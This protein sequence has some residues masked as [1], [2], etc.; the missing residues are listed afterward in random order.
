MSSSLTAY[1]AYLAQSTS[2]SPWKSFRETWT[3]C[4]ILVLGWKRNMKETQTEMNRFLNKF[5]ILMRFWYW[6][7]TQLLIQNSSQWCI[8]RWDNSQLCSGKKKK[9]V[10]AGQCFFLLSW[11]FRYQV[12]PSQIFLRNMCLSICIS[13]HR[14]GLSFNTCPIQMKTTLSLKNSLILWKWRGL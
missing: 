7:L 3:F 11:P 5:Q 14:S 12:I 8:S 9:R 13:W 4:S 6:I 1:P 10:Y 2:A